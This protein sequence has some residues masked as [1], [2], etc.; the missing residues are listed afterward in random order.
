MRANPFDEAVKTVTRH[1]ILDA[2]VG[3]K[4]QE[5]AVLCLKAALNDCP[6]SVPCGYL[7]REKPVVRAAVVSLLA[8]RFSPAEI[9]EAV[10]SDRFT[11]R[12]VE[13]ICARAIALHYLKIITKVK[14]ATEI[15]A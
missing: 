5:D 1:F 10:E 11:V 7:L 14:Y 12:S 4:L 13:L 15:K 3:T 2:F 6:P 9:A 8:M